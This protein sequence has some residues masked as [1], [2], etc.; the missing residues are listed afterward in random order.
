MLRGDIIEIRDLAAG[1][2][3]IELFVEESG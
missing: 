1:S 3:G 2:P